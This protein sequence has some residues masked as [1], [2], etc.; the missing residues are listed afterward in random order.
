MINLLSVLLILLLSK[1]DRCF[2]AFR[3]YVLFLFLFSVNCSDA[4]KENTHHTSKPIEELHGISTLSKEER[5]CPFGKELKINSKSVDG[6]NEILVEMSNSVEDLPLVSRNSTNTSL[7]L[8]AEAINIRL[9]CCLQCKVCMRDYLIIKQT[10]LFCQLI[11]HLA[12]SL[13]FYVSCGLSDSVNEQ[14][15]SLSEFTFLPSF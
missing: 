10:H 14:F 2:C 8:G 6:H 15:S 1:R 12:I 7:A 4:G 5:N 9:V 3:L 11:K 13:L